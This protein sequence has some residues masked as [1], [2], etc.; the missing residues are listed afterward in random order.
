MKSF[1]IFHN[2]SILRGMIISQ[3]QKAIAQAVKK[4]IGLDLKPSDIL[5]EHPE[6][7][8]F[9]DYSSNIVLV[10]AK[11]AKKKPLELAQKIAQEL[12]NSK[13]I[14]QLSKKIQAV[15]PGFINISIKN[16][17]FIKELGK[18]LNS[19]E[20]YGTSDIGKGQKWLIEHTSPNPNKAM[21]LGH[22]RNNVTGMAI[23]NIWEALGVKVI[24][25]CIDNNRGIAIAKLM[26]GYLK[27]GHKKRKKITDISY[28]YENQNEW[29]T[30]EEAKVRPDKF[31]DHLYVKAS[32]DFKDKEVEKRVRK[33]VVDWEKED[34]KTWA[35][36]EKVLSY[37]Y[38][39]QQLTLK[40]LGNK[41]DKV[42][43]EHEHYKKGKE[44]VGQGLKKGIFRKL[45]DGAILSDLKRYGLTDTILIKKD[46]SALYITQ[47]LALT[48]LKREN[49]K[50]DRLFWVIGPE[51]SLALKQLFAICEQLGIEKIDHFTHIAY[52]YMSIKGKGKMSSREG[53][54]VYIDDLLDRIEEMA[55]VLSSNA[56]FNEDN[57][58][59]RLKKLKQ[60]SRKRSRAQL[61]HIK[62][63]S[64][65]KD[66]AK[67]VAI[68]AVKYSILKVGRM[69]NIAFDLKE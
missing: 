63:Y 44:L 57:I 1:N 59:P 36:W 22:L 42:W 45:S 14:K 17:W 69:K 3:L 33:L 50:A 46:G 52:G 55:E 20:K 30:P 23:A 29:L 31:V 10:L 15:K 24:R 53:T 58:E 35:L 18:V 64:E 4:T 49:F 47:D 66:L 65:V 38:A 67:K 7:E 68:G 25:D 56:S 62:S 43:H 37:S 9:G 13:E 34:K 51:Q 61:D 60:K 12:E 16:E 27:F 2:F 11:K 6:N 54:V 40:R 48:K 21:H 26:W 39:G 41:W 32:G 5:I 19:T 8:E 28:W